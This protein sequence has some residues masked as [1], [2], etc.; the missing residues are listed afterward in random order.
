MNYWQALPPLAQG[1]VGFGL[2][3]LLLEV[4]VD[5]LPG[6]FFYSRRAFEPPPRTWAEQQQ[7]EWELRRLPRAEL[8]RPRGELP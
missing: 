2:F 7:P 8:E 3:L 6:R 5:L 4:V 1:V